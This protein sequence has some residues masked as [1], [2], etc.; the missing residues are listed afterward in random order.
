M[1]HNLLSIKLVPRHAYSSDSFYHDL[2]KPRRASLLAAVCRDSTRNT[3]AFLVTASSRS[4]T[5]TNSTG[6]PLAQIFHY[7]MIMPSRRFYK[8]CHDTIDATLI[9]GPAHH[10]TENKYLC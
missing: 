2:Q 5:L 10:T 4:A 6:G 3:R 9:P 1:I 7:V 8:I